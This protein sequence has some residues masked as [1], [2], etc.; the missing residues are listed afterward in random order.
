MK[1]KKVELR[2]RES[3]IVIYQGGGDRGAL[4]RCWSKD[5]IFQLGR[6]R[7]RDKLCAMLTTVNNNI[8]HT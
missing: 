1:C 8:L 4:G 2:E 5:E 3:R 7:S 6:I